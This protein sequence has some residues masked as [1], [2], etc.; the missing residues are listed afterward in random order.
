MG[1]KEEEPQTVPG[2]SERPGRCL[3]LRR[4]RPEA[5]WVMNLFSGLLMVPASKKMRS[6]SSSQVGPKGP[7]GTHGTQG[8]QPGHA[9]G[10][11]RC[12]LPRGP[13]L[14]PGI[15]DLCRYSAR[16]LLRAPVAA[17]QGPPQV[18]HAVGA[19][20]AAAAAVVRAEQGRRARGPELLGGFGRQRVCR[21][22]FGLTA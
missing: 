21:S 16:R 20:V 1:L 4:V 3:S 19:A 17:F 18:L 7:N 15:C 12:A 9:A 5:L 14:D 22:T 6:T 8:T 13:R 2:S 11:L 10:A